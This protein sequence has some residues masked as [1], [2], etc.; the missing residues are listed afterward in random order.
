[1][2]SDQLVRLVEKA[3]E[4]KKGKETEIIYV[5]EKTTLADYFVIITG[6]SAPHVRA[7]SEQI[8]LKLKQEEDIEALHVEGVESS[9]WI[10]LDFGGVVVHIFQES[11]RA[12]YS[13]EKLWKGRTK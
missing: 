12:F 7:L 5:G 10:L 4:D 3:A 1:M 13:L 2:N 9:K 6:T 11:E 8:Q